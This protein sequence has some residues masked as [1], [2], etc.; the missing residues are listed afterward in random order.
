[1]KRIPTT[2]MLA[3]VCV[4]ATITSDRA[5]AASA[6]IAG[7]QATAPPTFLASGFLG[8]NANSQWAYS[9]SLFE[10]GEFFVDSLQVPLRHTN[11]TVG[12]N[13]GGTFSI[14]LD[15]SGEPGGEIV[16]FDYNN[17][18]SAPDPV[19]VLSSAAASQAILESGVTYW[20]VGSTA[21]G[22]FNWHISDQIIGP[23][24]PG[25]LRTNGGPWM[26]QQFGNAGAF[27][28]FG[29]PVPEPSTTALCGLAA[30]AVLLERR[31]GRRRKL[32]PKQGQ[33]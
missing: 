10:P 11:P 23:S 25:G 19:E 6:P 20:L 13:V 7:T 14:H 3:I 5:A 26:I 4:A 17:I 18:P 1:M 30:I 21:S 27:V 16:S 31:T 33:R 24:N 2:V 9:F 22:Q 15:A 29:T 28:L 32:L 8:H 12:P